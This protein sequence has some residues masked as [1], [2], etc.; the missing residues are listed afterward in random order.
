MLTNKY[1]L[2]EAI[3][4]AVSNDD[5]SRGEADFSVTELV[6][7]PRY[8]QLRRR[9]G[10]EIVEDVADMGH[11]LMGKIAHGI[12]E[13]A[14]LLNA[15]HEE[16]LFTTVDGTT[17]SGALD[18]YAYTPDETLMDLKVTSVYATK[19]SNQKADWV[20][21]L[22]CYAELLRRHSFQPAKLQIIPVYKDWRAAEQKR[23]DWYPSHMLGQ[24]ITIAMWPQR[25]IDEYLSDRVAA[26]VAARDIPNDDL[27]VCT[28]LFR[29]KRPETF[30]VMK[31][32][33]AK[34]A[35]K[36]CATEG[37]ARTYVM[38]RGMTKAVIQHRPAEYPRCASYCSVAQFCSYGRE[39][40][41]Q[42]HQD[43]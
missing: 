43:V 5:Y 27:P 38:Q 9:H 10:H 34:R 2:P 6:A 8:I 18:H 4:A 16:R 1:N 32:P 35:T 13:K 30:A 12:L 23:N 29:W 37:D 11:I 20:A 19:D 28:D 17:I 33:K 26:H 14:N 39:Y 3:V 40:A 25:T 21:Q 41:R 42:A 22:N 36:L 7:E 24:P 31:T 15:L